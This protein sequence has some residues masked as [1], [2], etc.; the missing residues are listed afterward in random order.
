M[1]EQGNEIETNNQRMQSFAR[2][3]KGYMGSAPMIAAALPIP[4]TAGKIIPTFAE[5]T[6]Y[7]TTYT[8][9]FCF[10]MVALVFY[11]RHRLGSYLKPE[12]WDKRSRLYG[13]FLV[14][15]LP[16]FLVILTLFSIG[17]YHITLNDSIELLLESD[18]YEPST[19]LEMATIRE[20]SLTTQAKLMISYI[21][22]FL[23]ST[24]AFALMAV[25]EYMQ[26]ILQLSEIE[27]VKRS[28]DP[29]SEKSD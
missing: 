9:M 3:F 6:G 5:Q 16:F 28:A 15:W 23:A 10:L 29:F 18:Q 21:G 1:N 24:L 22:I 2:F 4:I 13:R 17:T 26:N 25:R 27:M 19:I 7:L 20:L 11:R 8:S 14:S 12:E